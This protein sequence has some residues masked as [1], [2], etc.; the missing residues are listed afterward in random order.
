MENQETGKSEKLKAWRLCKQRTNINVMV[1]PDK[2]GS[3]SVFTL[4]FYNSTVTG[5]GP[6]GRSK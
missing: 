2:F 6:G 5:Q 4:G 3:S 1:G